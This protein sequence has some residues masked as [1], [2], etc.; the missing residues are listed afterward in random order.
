MD[1]FEEVAKFIAKYICDGAVCVETGTS[2]CY[3]PNDPYWNTTSAL[4]KRICEPKNGHLFSVD[5]LNRSENINELF[6]LGATDRKKITLLVGHSVTVLKSLSLPRVD[7]L[8]LDSGENEDLL[9]DEFKAIKHL[10]SEN[11]YVLVDDIHNLGSVKYKK[12]V[13]LLKKLG[14]DWTEVSTP[15]GLF[16]SSKGYPIPEE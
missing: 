3:P 12:V 6:A 14:Y 9:V 10:L 16:V 7:L 15:T 5:M 4:V 11:H 8:C 1:R 13:P 2:Y